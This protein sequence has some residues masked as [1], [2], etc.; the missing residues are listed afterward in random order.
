[1]SVAGNSA[2][3]RASACGS[4]ICCARNPL[5]VQAIADPVSAQS[6]AQ[7]PATY[8]RMAATQRADTGC[9]IPAPPSTGRTIHRPGRPSSSLCEKTYSFMKHWWLA[10][11]MKGQSLILIVAGDSTN[12]R[13]SRDVA[14]RSKSAPFN[15]GILGTIRRPQSTGLSEALRS[16]CPNILLR[17]RKIFGQAVTAFAI[18]GP[19]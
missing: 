7:T 10:H 4:M 9:R 15:I 14:P 17:G 19:I 11:Y 6:A 2:R 8:S 16:V 13:S 5:Q 1:M 12:S 18:Q 3:K